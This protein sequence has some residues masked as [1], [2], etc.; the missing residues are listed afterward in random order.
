MDEKKDNSNNKTISQS[1]QIEKLKNMASYYEEKGEN[2]LVKDI[3]SNV[4]SQKTNGTLNNEQIKMFA[5]KISPLLNPTQRDRL[6]ELIAK[7]L[8]L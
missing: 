4:I 7:L 3:F 2:Q 5:Q 8:E 1:E 6:N